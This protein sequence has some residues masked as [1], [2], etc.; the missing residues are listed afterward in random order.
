MIGKPAGSGSEYYFYKGFSSI[1]LLAFVDEDYKFIF[2]DVGRNGALSDGGV[3]RH[4][5]MYSKL[6]DGTLNLPDPKPLPQ[7]SEPEWIHEQSK[8]NIPFFF[9]GDEAFPLGQ[10]CMKPYSQRQLDMRKRIFN[11]RLSRMRLCSEN[12]FGIWVNRFRIFVT[13]MLLSPGK[14]AIIVL[15]SLCLHNMLRD[16]S[17]NSYTPDGYTDMEKENG[18]VHLVTRRD[19]DNLVDFVVHPKPNY[20]GHNKPTKSSQKIRDALADHFFGPGALPWQWEMI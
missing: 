18:T 16:L 12:A 9:V 4:C 5:D 8:E 2:A 13:R 1:V 3:Y 17:R 7:S 20:V 10:H 15:C 6:Q 11:Y 14:A 19:N